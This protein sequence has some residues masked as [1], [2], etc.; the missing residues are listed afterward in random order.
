LAYVILGGALILAT[1]CCLALWFHAR[2]T[3]MMHVEEIK[4]A[5]EAEK[6]ALVLENIKKVVQRERDLNEYLAHEVRNPLSAAMTA[7]SFLCFAHQDPKPILPGD[8][9]HKTIQEDIRTIQNSLTYINDLLRSMLDIHKARD[10]QVTL[11]NTPT[12]IKKDILEPVR[13]ILSR[14]TSGF[15]ILLN[16]PDHLLVMVDRMRLKQ[17][18]LNLASNA[19]KFVEKGYIRI[20]AEIAAGD[21]LRMSV[22]DSGPGIPE[23]KRNK[24]FARFQESL[25]SL[26]QGT[27][28]GLSLC[29]SLVK[30]MG[31][32]IYLDESYCSDVEGCPGARF[33]VFIKAPRLDIESM[34]L[35]QYKDKAE[36]LP[37]QHE[38]E[39]IAAKKNI[40]R[41]E[42]SQ[43]L[44]GSESQNSI[45]MTL[46]E[47]LSVLVVDD[48]MILRKLLSR[49]IK[50]VAPAWNIEEAANGETALEMATSTT[51]HLIFMD[52][53]MASVEKQLLGTETVAALRA[54]GVQSR[55]CGLSANDLGDVFRKA[56]A[57]Y[58]ILKPFRCEKKALEEDL[59]HVLYD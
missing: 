48:D 59:L 42:T 5:V 23:G 53:Y 10:K 30:L 24:L 41:Q 1:C 19:R 52:Q 50:R 37:I 27:G 57:D 35:D 3:R 4:S 25:D 7:C 54:K 16:C 55:I 45:K 32:R 39:R 17:V 29:R 38:E 9:R 40:L 2:L 26:N 12:D 46:P 44:N 56:G 43:T 8:E 58:F 47:E 13:T 18:I 20:N 21:H 31:G 11:V 51:Y 33:V 15:E 14:H 22:E 6:A 28:I 49:S 36:I 34:D